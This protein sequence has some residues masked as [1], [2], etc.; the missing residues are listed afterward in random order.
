M[1]HF[2]ANRKKRKKLIGQHILIQL[3]LSQSTLTMNNILI[4]IQLLGH[5]AFLSLFKNENCVHFFYSQHWCSIEPHDL[6]YGAQCIWQSKPFHISS[7]TFP[8]HACTWLHRG[9]VFLYVNSSSIELWNVFTVRA[10]WNNWEKLPIDLIHASICDSTRM[11]NCHKTIMRSNK[12][13]AWEL[14]IC[15]QQNPM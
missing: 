5:F 6:V 2:C 9:G 12:K 10:I 14:Y 4:R 11:K 7:R 3:Q 13:N 8:M 1:I 15:Q